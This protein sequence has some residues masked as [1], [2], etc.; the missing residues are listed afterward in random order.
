MKTLVLNLAELDDISRDIID[1]TFS[2]GPFIE[3]LEQR[4]K[5]EHSIKNKF[6][7]FV[8]EKMHEAAK[9]GTTIT[10]ENISN[11]SEILELI[12]ISLTQLMD[13]ETEK[14]WGLGIPMKPILFYGTDGIYN[15]MLD[16]TQ[17]QKIK[18]LEKTTEEEMKIKFE[19]IYSFVLKKMFGCHRERPSE[20]I[21][22]VIDRETS[23]PKYYKI[24]FDKRFIK[25]HAKGKLPD[26]DGQRFS[27]YLD[28][29]ERMDKL[30]E[31]I[32]INMFS[33]EGMSVI[34]LTD[35]TAEHAI[36]NI[37]NTIINQQLHTLTDDYYENIIQS[38]KALAGC[39]EV[40]FGMMPVLKVNDKLIF[41]EENCL[42]SKLVDTARK[43][44]VEQ[45][46]YMT[47]ADYYFKNPKLLYFETITEE[48]EKKQVFLKA[49]K[50]SGVA[51]YALLPVFYN[52]QVAGV[53]EVHATKEGLLGPELLGRLSP[54]MPFIAQLLQ[55][56]VDRFNAGIEN[57]I[58]DK[59]TSLQPS[60]QW[61]FKEAALHY[62]QQPHNQNGKQEIEQ[63]I[64]K[65]VYPL[66]GAIDIRNSSIERNNATKDD[67]QYQLRLLLQT[68][69]D[70]KKD[71]PFGLIDEM[72]YKAKKWQTVL[73]FAPT[74][75][76]EYKLN[77][78]LE[79]ET[80][81]FLDHIKLTRPNN[82]AAINKYMESLDTVTGQS[83]EN[84][85]N[86]EASMQLI[87]RS[88]ITYLDRAN[89]DLQQSYPFYFEKFRTDGI[90]YDI[91]I[92]QSI[93]PG[94][95]F[96]A[97]YLKNLRLWQLQSMAAIYKMA[98]GLQ[99]QMQKELY[100]T[101]LIFI[102]ADTIDISFRN[103]EKKFDVEGAYNIRYQLIKKRI[104][105][106]HIKDSGERLTQPGK[107]ALIYFN[108]KE[109]KEY[110]EY[111]QYLQE[112]NVFTNDLEELE[113]EEL[114]GVNGLKAL[115]ITVSV[116]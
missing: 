113:L 11:Y 43:Y 31:L 64:F 112:Q 57:V 94:R 78:F 63:I 103:D 110:K 24:S 38:L 27:D 72:I 17:K 70:I 21:H 89:A 80:I 48:D 61:K 2:F 20:I 59:F 13:D 46:M 107:I 53:L 15:I 101:Q 49:L 55:S 62:M 12:Y 45:Q 37:K 9:N 73:Q 88:I 10:A 3:Y 74:P 40:E 85:R 28:E 14:L 69:D 39:S 51:S 41:D 50:Q 6:Y 1:S 115:R 82:G 102:N 25:V 29:K 93:S 35:V 114:Q 71:Y 91:Y 92:G 47:V 30:R 75:S 108:N 86:L 66:Y 81:P 83:H 16:K 98:L 87:N 116:D 109:A 52:N 60:V 19:I 58:K 54:A 26:I 34:T 36:E 99:P 5:T 104:D 105:K 84:R 22:T 68:L 33:F 111:I 97:I 18:I 42:R 76:E 4:V 95:P 56:N 32:P 77:N 8:L 96:D 23:M 106:V 90:E 65:N 79:A 7:S 67:L 44:G 100:I